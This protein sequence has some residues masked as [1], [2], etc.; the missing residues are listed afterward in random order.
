MPTI[1][2]MD[3]PARLAAVKGHE[4]RRAIR[5]ADPTNN[6]AIALAIA[7]A[8]ELDRRWMEIRLREYA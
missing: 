1:D 7:L 6:L 4:L 2:I 5:D 3:H 8:D